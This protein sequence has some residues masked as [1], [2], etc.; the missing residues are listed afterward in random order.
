MIA[1]HTG[2][3]LPEHELAARA[4]SLRALAIRPPQRA[5]PPGPTAPFKSSRTDPLNREP[6]AKPGP[7]APFKPFRTDP[8]NRE[9]GAKPGSIAPFKPSR[10]NPLNREPAAKRGPVAPFKPSRIDPL[11][12]EQ[13]AEPS[14]TRLT[15]TKAEA[16][17]TTTWPRPDHGPRGRTRPTRRPPAFHPGLAHPASDARNRQRRERSAQLPGRAAMPHTA[18][19]TSTWHR[20][21]SPRGADRG[22]QQHDPR[23]GL[24]VMHMGQRQDTRAKQAR[25]WRCPWPRL[26]QAISTIAACAKVAQRGLPP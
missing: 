7:V 1:P 26:L 16:L 19:H 25:P 5:P 11:N 8:L 24:I 2:H 18:R 3:S 4:A 9:P 20:S 12:R 21:A 6:T 22:S 17:R 13:P 14:L 15:P 23:P 10:T